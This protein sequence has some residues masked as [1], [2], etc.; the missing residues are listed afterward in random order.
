MEELDEFPEKLPIAKKL[1]ARQAKMEQKMSE[2]CRLMTQLSL[3]A[4]VFLEELSFMLCWFLCPGHG[5]VMV[6][7]V[8]FPL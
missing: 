7:T 3:L 5:D 6:G 2:P 1:D 4:K 8:T